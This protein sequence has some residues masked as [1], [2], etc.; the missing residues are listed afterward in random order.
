MTDLPTRCPFGAG[1]DL[2]DPGLLE[3][4]LPVDEL[5]QM[6][7]ARQIFWIDQEPGSTPFQDDGY[8]VVTRHA[9]IRAISKNSVDWSTTTQGA[10]MRLPDGVTP[11]L[12]EYTKAL[13]INHD[14]PEHT[15]LRKVVSRLFTPRAVNALHTILDERARAIVGK[16]V[17]GGTGNFVHDVAVDL[18][19]SAIADLIGVPEQDL[20]LIH[21]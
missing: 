19:L 8:W 10:V 18:P 7:A 21:I 3:R 16:A 5:A 2:T 20:S 15:R 6:R 13:L 4:G 9:D 12:L 11:E 14:P 1:W 17:A